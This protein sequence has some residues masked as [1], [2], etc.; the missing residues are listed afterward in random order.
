MTPASEVTPAKPVS[1]NLKE[2]EG[3]GCAGL[4]EAKELSPRLVVGTVS[5]TQDFLLWLLISE[6]TEI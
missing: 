2:I 6:A 5:H 1:R 4:C 3:G